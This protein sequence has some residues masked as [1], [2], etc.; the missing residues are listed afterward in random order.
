MKSPVLSTVHLRIH[1]NL[2]RIYTSLSGVSSV[3]DPGTE[4][5]GEIFDVSEKALD[6]EEKSLHHPRTF[7]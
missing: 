5:L 3:L 4:L 6:G 2:R 1:P 7:K